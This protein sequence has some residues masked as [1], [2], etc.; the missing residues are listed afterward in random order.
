[1]GVIYS[2]TDVAE[3][4]IPS[5]D[6][7]LQAA[8]AVLRLGHE[9]GQI[10]LMVVH[11]SVTDNRSNIRSDLDV[12]IEYQFPLEESELDTVGLIK[13]GLGNVSI[14]TN[15][16]IEPAIWPEHEPRQSR[17]ER[18]SDILFS[19]YL[20]KSMANDRWR[21]GEPDQ[22]IY[23]IARSTDDLS[24]VRKAVIR[25]STVKHNDFLKAPSTFSEERA[26]LAAMQ[27]ALELPKATLQK[28]NQL[29][30]A[31]TGHT[32]NEP[33]TALSNLSGSDHLIE[34]LRALEDINR[35]YTVLVE[36]AALGYDKS[37]QSDTHRSWLANNYQPALKL[38]VLA[39]AD[40]INILAQHF[41]STTS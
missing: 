29:A 37:E 33:Y 31:E 2:S 36:H 20:A 16:R 9:L 38:G 39:S 23:D 41:D 10:A 17:E 22:V 21:V 35:E 32:P 12:F 5:Q 15:V 30:L 6:Q 14:D 27:R 4:L 40:F 8:E 19:R 34:T 1:M 7:H 25:Y 26:C 18:F 11:G 13:A 24:I 3:G 28:A